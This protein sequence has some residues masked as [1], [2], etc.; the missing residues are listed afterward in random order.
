MNK[1]CLTDSTRPSF[2]P[3]NKEVEEQLKKKEELL[4]ILISKLFQ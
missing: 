4:K 3:A 1:S 2:L